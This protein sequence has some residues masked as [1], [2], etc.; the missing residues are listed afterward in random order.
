[1]LQTRGNTFTWLGHAAFRIT[2]PSGK[3]VVVD[4]WVQSNPACPEPLKKFHRLDTILITHGH[5]DHIADA[6]ALAKEF[7]PQVVAIY[8]ICAWLESKGVTQTSAM[9]KGGT[10]KVGEIEVTMVNALHSCGIQD[11]DKIIYGGEACGY[12]IRL[13]GGLTVYHAG[14]TAVFGDMKLIA[15]LYAP[16]V[17]MLPIG[18]HFTMGPREA[19]HA[20]R[21]L[22]VRHVIPMHFGTF[23]VLTGNPEALRK[24]TQDIPGLEI[25]ALKPGESVG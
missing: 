3:V 18:D 12:I 24:L 1:M 15:E 9:N 17:A 23:P 6:V 11:G 22:G 14:D 5:F 4:P 2:T 10:Q 7:E 19:A 13:P 21:L 25:H 20:I 8:E 16:E